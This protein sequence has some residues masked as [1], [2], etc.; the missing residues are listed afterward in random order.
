MLGSP[1]FTNTYLITPEMS[2]VNTSSGP[3]N[4]PRTETVTSHIITD[5]NKNP[6]GEPNGGCKERQGGTISLQMVPEGNDPLSTSNIRLDTSCAEQDSDCEVRPAE[7]RCA[8]HTNA[9]NP[10]TQHFQED[11]I[12]AGG[13]VT[14]I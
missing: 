1:Y 9:Q 2:E 5:E 4:N 7:E 10:A 8:T 11:S 3:G 6:L 13:T 14:T 12:D